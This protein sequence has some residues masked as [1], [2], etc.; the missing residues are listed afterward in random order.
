M[1]EVGSIT[2]YVSGRIVIVR[3]DFAKSRPWLIL[4]HYDLDTGGR[5]LFLAGLTTTTIFDRGGLLIPPAC[6]PGH[7]PSAIGSM[8]RFL[9]IGGDFG[10][11]RLVDAGRPRIPHDLVVKARA[12]LISELGGLR[13]E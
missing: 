12:R 9:T 4:G 11:P 10:C 2:D 3:L 13:D 6:N 8:Y 7:P 5:R 1:T